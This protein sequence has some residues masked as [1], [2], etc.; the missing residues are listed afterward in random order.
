MSTLYE[1][2]STI[3]FIPRPKLYGVRNA[4]DTGCRQN[5][6]TTISFSNFLPKFKPLMRQCGQK[7]DSQTDPQMTI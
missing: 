6:N 2:L 1:N 4:A 7:W 3:M 5:Q